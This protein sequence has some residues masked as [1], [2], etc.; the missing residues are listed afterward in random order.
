MKTYI[1][2]LRGINVSGHKIIKMQL[3]RDVLLQIGFHNV[4]TYIQSGNVIFQT[5][6][7]DKKIIE[8]EI[9]SCIQKH[10]GHEVPVIVI[11]PEELKSV[12]ERNPHHQESLDPA[13]PYVAF[14]SE[15]PS[16]LLLKTLQKM[17]FKG[18]T[19]VNQD[20]TLYLHYAQSAADTKLT[21][22]VIERMLQIKSTTRNWKT[23]LQ[24]MTLVDRTTT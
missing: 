13:Q 21:N 8:N 4:S 22:T 1:A 16:P 5:N 20:A 12:I 23:V 2:L 24:L 11:T 15:K 17:D 3:L 6:L 19:F 14:L 10:F 7:L 9:A 18:D